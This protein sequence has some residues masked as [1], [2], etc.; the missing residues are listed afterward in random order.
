MGWWSRRRGRG[1]SSGEQ[2]RGQERRAAAEVLDQW[3]AQR[4]GIEVF[5][6]PRTTVTATTMLL[7]A[8]NGEFTRRPMASPAAVRTFAARHALPVYD[9]NLVGYPQRMRDYSRRQTILQQRAE[10]DRL[11]D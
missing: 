7:V 2:S 11:A 10:H 9:A 1:S 4:R 5:I 8:D 3:I 6:E